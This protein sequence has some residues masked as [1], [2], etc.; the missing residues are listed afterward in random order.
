MK[1]RAIKEKI[2]KSST[3]YTADTIESFENLMAIRQRPTVFIQS[4]G[5]NGVMRV[6]DEIIGNVIDEFNA[7]RGNEV[8][9]AID[10]NKHIVIVED[11]ASG[12]PLE[13][14]VDVTTKIFTG[15]KFG[16]SSY[17]GTSRGLNGLGLKCGV[18]LSEYLIADSYRDRK[19][20]HGVYKKGAVETI[21]F[22]DEKS[23]KHGTR[24]EYKPDIEIFGDI[25]MNKMQYAAFIEIITYINSGMIVRFKYNSDP[26]ITYYHPEGMEGYF[27]DKIIKQKKLRVVCAPIAITDEKE[28]EVEVNGKPVYMWYFIYTA[29]AENLYAEYLE[30]YVNGLETK[31][32]GTHVTGFHAAVTDAVKKYIQIHKLLPQNIKFEITGN[33]IRESCCTLVMVKHSAPIFSTQVKDSLSNQDIQ[34]FIKASAAKYLASWLEEHPKEANEIC[35]LAIRSAKAKA[36]AKEAKENIIRSGEKTSITDIDPKKYNGCKSNNPEERELFIVEGDSAGGSAQEAR[37]TNYQAVFRIR[38]K[39]QNTHNKKNPSFSEEL[40]QLIQ[41]LGCGSPGKEFDIRKLR[42]HK[43]VKAADADSDGYHISTLIDGFFFKF[44]RPLIEAGYLYEARPPLYQI[45]FDE[46][47]K[48]E[49]SIFIPDERYFKKAVTAIATGLTECMTLKGDVLSRELTELYI[50]KIQGFKDCIEGY[51]TQINISPLLLEFIVRFYSRIV[52]KDFK[53]LYA[54]GYECS[55]FSES[56]SFLHLTVDKEYEHYFIVIDSLFYKNIYVPLYKRLSEI[57][58]TDIKFKGKNTGAY[59][60]GST[61]LNALFLN[62]MLLGGG[63]V[64][65]RRLKGLGESGPQELRYYLFNPMTRTINKIKLT[66]AAYAEKQFDIFLGNNLE[67]KKKLFIIN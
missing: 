23:T 41:I 61:Y 16:K 21:E 20:A 8:D 55:V 22:L 31:D 36:A 45:I 12:I 3:D 40:L 30:S 56:L 52:K 9:V 62:N 5:Q 33:D 43:I 57:Y 64:K 39:I 44:Y 4:L 27:K 58:L 32:N 14:F 17:G 50:R 42:F 2:M 53:P 25:E 63:K 7:G 37:N 54:L 35:R 51:A 19:R 26:V 65:I 15:G 18:A 13:K 47:K 60:G 11:Y 66:D 46:G 24:I 1:Q 29:W 48:S 38:G 28:T 6:F 10:N 34:F 67:E 59:Y 49:K